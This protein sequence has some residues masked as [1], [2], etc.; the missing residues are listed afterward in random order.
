VIL[1]GSRGVNGNE[2][3]QEESEEFKENLKQ[4]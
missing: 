2:E 1:R 4:K 3:V